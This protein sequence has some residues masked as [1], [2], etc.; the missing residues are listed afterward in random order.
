[1]SL[2]QDCEF[3]PHKQGYAVVNT[4]ELCIEAVMTL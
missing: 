3:V 1:M 4:K 2:W